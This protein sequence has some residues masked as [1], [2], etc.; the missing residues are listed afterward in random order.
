[1]QKERKAIDNVRIILSKTHLSLFT[2]SI[3]PFWGHCK[4]QI[5]VYFL[6]ICSL[7]DDRS[8]HNVVKVYC[9]KSECMKHAA[10]YIDY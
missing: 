9:V 10:D 7:I 4:N 1:M 8:R 6:R 3:W 5:Y 2:A